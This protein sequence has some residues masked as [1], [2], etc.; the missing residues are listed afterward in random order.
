MIFKKPTPK[1]AFIT[2]LHLE[3]LLALLFIAA[4][5]YLCYMIALPFLSVIVWAVTLTMLFAP[6]QRWLDIRSR[7]ASMNALLNTLV[8]GVI[9]I[10][11]IVFATTQLSEQVF[12]SARWL[13]HLIETDQWQLLLNHPN[14]AK[15]FNEV[16]AVID[17]PALLK[18]INAWLLGLSATFLKNST[19]NVLSAGLIFYVLFFMLRDRHLALNDLKNL[20]PL[21][22]IDM[23]ALFHVVDATV[24]AIFLGTLAIALIQGFL[25]GIMFWGL[26]LPAPFVWGAVMALASIIP[27]LG[28][29]IVWVP[30]VVY[31]LII[32]DLGK[33]LTLTLWGMFVIGTVDNL[34]RPYWVSSQ[35]NLH[36]L[37]I[38]FS[39]TG[40]V[41]VY[42]PCGLI[43]GPV[44][45]TVTRFLIMLWKSH[46]I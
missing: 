8:I 15:Y 5:L 12:I 3:M 37:L 22:P 45:F 32:G 35:L 29:F 20:S 30:A 13:Q 40:G 9:V 18:S 46:R 4:G 16:K 38:F 24:K 33:A 6:L 43:L 17:F 41:I 27:M 36:P 39:I 2:S 28:A 19:L 14:M 10:V 44:T 21:N 23:Q 31:L 25:G 42:G 1:K 26:G 11:P 34:L 7:Y